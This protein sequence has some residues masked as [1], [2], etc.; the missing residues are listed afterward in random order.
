MA[1]AVVTEWVSP[2]ITAEQGFT[3]LACTGGVSLLNLLTAAND[4]HYEV[5]LTFDMP[6]D[7]DVTNPANYVLTSMTGGIAIAI[8]HIV[9]DPPSGGSLYSKVVRLFLTHQ[10]SR[11]ETYK[12]DV[13]GLT[14]PAGEALGVSSAT[15]VATAYLAALDY[16]GGVGFTKNVV[17]GA[18]QI[19]WYG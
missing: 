16:E 6:P 4:S 19:A 13:A 3:A 14:G 15:W 8:D 12:V 11:G 10:G 1:D 5:L 17:A 9:I 18:P 7:G 2:G